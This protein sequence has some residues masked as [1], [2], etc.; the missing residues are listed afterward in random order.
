VDIHIDPGF[1]QGLRQPE[2]VAE[3]AL[4]DAI[5]AGVAQLAHPNISQE[6]QAAIVNAI[7]PGPDARSLHVFDA[8][9]YR[10]FIPRRG[11]G[12]PVLADDIDSAMFRSGLGWKVQSQDLGGDVAGAD[13]CKAFLNAVVMIVLDELCASLKTFDRKQLVELLLHNHEAVE[14]E[15]ARWRRTARANIAM[16]DDRESAVATIVTRETRFTATSM[17]CRILME[18]AIC[19]CPDAGGAPPGHID[20]TRLMAQALIAYHWGGYSDVIHWGAAEARLRITPLGDVHFD[21]QFLETV[22]EPFGRT[23]SER[24]VIHA[25]ESYP[26]LFS[27]AAPAPA[28][29]E[30]LDSQFVAAWQAEFNASIDEL[31][32]FYDLIEDHCQ[33]KGN[34]AAVVMR[35]HE[36]VRLM[37]EATA[38]EAGESAD[39]LKQ[40]VLQPRPSWRTPGPGFSN[41]DWFPWRFRRRYATVRAPFLQLDAREDPEIAFAPGLARQ[42]YALTVRAY[43]EAEIP[44]SQVKSGAMRTWLGTRNHRHRLAFNKQ[45]SERMA[46]LGWKVRKEMTLPALIGGGLDRN[47]GDV[48]VVAWHTQTGRVLLMECKDVQFHR[49]M[50]EVAEQLHDFRGELLADGKPDLLKKHLDRVAIIKSCS[51]A[52]ARALKV[53][54][55]VTIEGHIV[56]KNPVPMR[57]VAD[58][59]VAKIR[60]SLF[61]ELDQL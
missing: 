16:H 61:D 50:G 41:K 48:D 42:A 60:V 55:P 33:E 3:R 14:C 2:N 18:A 29:A 45:V 56:F 40:F 52:V 7:C 5:I 57:F 24:Q 43:Y 15:R 49:A 47:Y 22:Y 59:L 17:A 31:R 6:Q 21:P 13:A 34:N 12:P 35:C 28:V 1:D 4:I 23:G 27:P 19:E 36:V 30:K 53:G 8:R 39:V 44:Q 9:A 46:E 51:S 26:E 37:M 32:R 54:G 58:R 11:L 25:A 10:D 20:L 38:K